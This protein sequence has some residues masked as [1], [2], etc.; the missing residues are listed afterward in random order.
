M[1]TAIKTVIANALK[2]L[3]TKHAYNADTLT[4]DL[5]AILFGGVVP[6]APAEP[7]DS[8]QK[9]KDAAAKAA[10]TRA[11][12]KKKKEEGSNAAAAP[13]AVV[14]PVELN[15]AKF[16]KT[17]TKHLKTGLDGA[18]RELNDAV[19]KQFLDFLNALSPAD[20]KKKKIPEH[21][22]D[23]MR[24][25]VAAPAE[26]V[27]DGVGRIVFKGKVYWVGK[28][29]KKVFRDENDEENADAAKVRAHVGYWNMNEF[30]TMDWDKVEW[31]EESA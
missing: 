11:A 20:F 27:P 30:K 13:A 29:S 12:N 15:L 16:T 24:P 21:V 28:V 23:F 25:P 6:E 5:F 9:K 17:H 22:T 31:E 2:T 19:E 14:V 10:A 8:A 18:H 7:A 4:A 3:E 26:A 1:E